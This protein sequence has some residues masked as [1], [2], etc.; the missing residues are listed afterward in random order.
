[1]Y[2]LD[3]KNRTALEGRTNLRIGYAMILWTQ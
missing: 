2:V 3:I 1:M